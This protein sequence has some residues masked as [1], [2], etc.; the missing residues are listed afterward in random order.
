MR[1]LALDRDVIWTQL[2]VPG[3]WLV[4]SPHSVP[5]VDPP[6]LPSVSPS[7]LRRSARPTSQHGQEP[8]HPTGRLA[9]PTGVEHGQV[10]SFKRAAP[11]ARSSHCAGGKNPF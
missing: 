1:R 6:S 8:F 10:G 2:T 7:R 9:E 5:T 11:P 3:K 4:N